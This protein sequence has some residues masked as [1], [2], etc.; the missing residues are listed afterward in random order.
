MTLPAAEDRRSLPR[1][2]VSLPVGGDHRRR[3][4]TV[5]LQHRGKSAQNL[6]RFFFRGKDDADEGIR[7]FDRGENPRRA[8]RLSQTA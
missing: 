4:R 6:L 8:L 5:P 2:K 3:R 1:G 7:V